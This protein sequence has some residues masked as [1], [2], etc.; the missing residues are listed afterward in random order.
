M[1]YY[2]VVCSCGDYDVYKVKAE[3]AEEAEELVEEEIA[4]Y[5]E[6]KDV[7]PKHEIKKIENKK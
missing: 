1:T 2:V 6:I 7:I 4:P 3:S 5:E